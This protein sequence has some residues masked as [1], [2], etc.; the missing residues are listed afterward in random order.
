MGEWTSCPKTSVLVRKEVTETQR[1]EAS[2]KKQVEGVVFPQAENWLGCF[3][4]LEAGRQIQKRFSEAP[5]G[6]N[7]IS[8]D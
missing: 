1:K 7:P 2:M 5:R 3:Q 4:P 6:I 8:P